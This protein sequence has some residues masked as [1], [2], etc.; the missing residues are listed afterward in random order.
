[1]LSRAVWQRYK[2]KI[3]KVIADIFPQYFPSLKITVEAL[4]HHFPDGSNNWLLVDWYALALEVRSKLLTLSEDWFP[5]AK[6]LY[7]L[8]VIP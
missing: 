8:L 5:H 7:V 2:L 4:G 3:T 6:I 1:M